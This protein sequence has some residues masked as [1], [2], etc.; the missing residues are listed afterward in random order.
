MKRLWIVTEL[1]YP[2][3][4]STAYILTK[5]ANKL[6]ENVEVH[7]ICG[8]SSYQ[9]SKSIEPKSIG[10]INPSVQIHRVS[11]TK[12]DKN[13]LIMRI[14]RFILL[15]CKLSRMLWKNLKSEDQVF[16][17]T[18]P[19]PLLVLVSLI[20]KIKGNYLYILVHDVF[21][22]NTIPA[23]IISSEKSLFYR[24]LRSVF[25]KAYR[26]ADKLIVLGRDM[27]DVMQQKLGDNPHNTQ[28]TII[29][30]WAECDSIHAGF[31]KSDDCA[32]LIDIQY[33]GNLGR[34]QGLMS[35]LEIIKNAKNE[36]LRF[37][38]WGNG[39]VKKDMENYV[40]LHDLKNIQFGGSYKRRE[41]NSILNNCDL[42]IITLAEGMRGLGVPSKT[43]NILATGKPIL[44]IGDLTSEVALLLKEH[45]VGYCFASNDKKG[46]LN[47]FQAISYNYRVEFE[48]K[49]RRARN[50][51]EKL[52]SEHIILKKYSDLILSDK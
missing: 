17:V 28:I 39:A 37:S 35:L 1:F 7:V 33:A 48:E 32:D 41:Q 29:E 4:T 2:E 6:A 31:L 30:N 15:S 27:K 43:Y 14:L 52:Y 38:F 11:E 20:K 5:I 46:L 10:K 18:N 36:G 49:G 16:I 3:E 9:D 13:K 12:L 40:E 50:L 42:A 22:E 26:S 51:A 19:A 21:P 8:P 24:M 45:D 25:N 47:F 44:F 23:K 34:V